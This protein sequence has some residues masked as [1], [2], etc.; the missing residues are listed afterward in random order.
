MDACGRPAT[1]PWHVRQRAPVP[2]P[3]GW[4]FL[5]AQLL[6]VLSSSHCGTVVVDGNTDRSMDGRVSRLAL[7]CLL[8]VILLVLG[9]PRPRQA[10]PTSLLRR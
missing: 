2:V 9:S 1:G 10:T 5:H 3:T 7:S 6:Q 4:L 8:D